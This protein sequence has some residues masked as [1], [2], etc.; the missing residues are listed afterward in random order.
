MIL[1]AILSHL[2]VVAS[3]LRPQR[4]PKRH[5]P[6]TASHEP[7]LRVK[8]NKEAGD[9]SYETKEIWTS[10]SSLHMFDKIVWYPSKSTVALYHKDVNEPSSLDNPDVQQTKQRWS[11]ITFFRSTLSSVVTFLGHTYG[12]S[13]LSKSVLYVFTLLGSLAGGI[14]WFVTNGH[15]PARAVSAGIS[16]NDAALL[17]SLI[18]VGSFVGRVGHGIVIDRGWMNREVLFTASFGI[19]GLLSFINP[20]LDTFATLSVFSCLFGVFHGAANSLVYAMMRLQV[21]PSEGAAALS[22]GVLVLATA[23]TIGGV[24]AG[25]YKVCY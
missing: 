23:N 8:A 4:K 11:L 1:S 24:L 20:F 7:A 2:F 12:L 16:Q 21:A 6:P 14:G 3:L 5:V 22:F 10:T 9:I 19:T 18:G 17:L 25:M 15:L 13:A